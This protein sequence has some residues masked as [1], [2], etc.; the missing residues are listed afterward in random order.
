LFGIALLP[1]KNCCFRSVSTIQQKKKSTS[2]QDSE[3]REKKTHKIPT[4]IAFD[5]TKAHLTSRRMQKRTRRNPLREPHC[6]GGESL[7]K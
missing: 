5:P 6:A 2:T 1:L 3:A 4:H 7:N